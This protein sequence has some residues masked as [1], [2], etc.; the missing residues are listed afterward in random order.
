MAN[1]T[2]T[3]VFHFSVSDEADYPLSSAL[4]L[5]LLLIATV[6]DHLQFMCLY[7]QYSL[8]THTF[9]KYKLINQRLALT[10]KLSCPLF[11]EL[12]VESDR[13]QGCFKRLW[14]PQAEVIWGNILYVKVLDTYHSY[15]IAYMHNH[16][17]LITCSI[18]SCDCWYMS[19]QTHTK[20]CIHTLSEW[21]VVALC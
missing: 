8:V 9:I 11:L 19:E 21:A 3:S 4:H 7:L 20:T 1:G 14:G 2:E 15:T 13:F 18:Q 17:R 12:W 6:Y 16:K 5:P 10:C